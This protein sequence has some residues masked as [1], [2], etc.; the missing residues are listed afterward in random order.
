M[1]SRSMRFY[2]IVEAGWLS[3]RRVRADLQELADDI[4]WNEPGA[5]VT[6]REYA[7]GWFNHRFRLQAEGVR[8]EVAERLEAQFA[9]TFVGEEEK[10][11]EG[12]HGSLQ[13]T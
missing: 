6:I 2:F 7:G 4:R 10:G 5:K 11:K 12:G 1:M 8:A 13:D 3:A 9:A